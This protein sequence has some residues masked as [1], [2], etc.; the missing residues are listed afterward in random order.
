MALA[1]VFFLVREGVSV[2]QLVGIDVL[3]KTSFQIFRILTQR[4]KKVQA[5][6]RKQLDTPLEHINI[7]GDNNLVQGQIILNP[8]LAIRILHH[9][10]SIGI[11]PSQQAILR[12]MDDKLD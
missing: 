8:P 11:K 3:N 4:I 5:L 10:A 2:A 6:Y 7:T 9:A 1:P 12:Q